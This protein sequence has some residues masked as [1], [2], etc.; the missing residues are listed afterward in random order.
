MERAVSLISSQDTKKMEPERSWSDLQPEILSLIL[1]NLF[2]GDSSNFRATC[3]SWKSI[4]P[5]FP[6][7]NESLLSKLPYLMTL[8]GSDCKIFQPLLKEMY[9]KEIPELKNARIRF[10]KYGWLLMSQGESSVFFFHPFTM[11]KIKLPDLPT[12]NWFHNMCFLNRPTSSDCTVI[13]ISHYSAGMEFCIIKRGADEWTYEYLE[14]NLPFCM[15]AASPVSH[16]GKPYCLG[17]GGNVG[18][19]DLSDDEWMYWDVLIKPLYRWPCSKYRQ[20]F[21]VKCDDGNGMLVVY[22][23]RE[24][25]RVHVKKLKLLEMLWEDVECLGDKMIF[26]SHG[27]S[28]LQDAV[29]K[30]MANKIYFPKFRGESGVFYSLDTGMFHSIV[31]DYPCR[32][33]FKLADQLSCTWLN[34]IKCSSS[35]TLSTVAE[36]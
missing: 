1:S 9:H 30:G 15:S 24:D 10:S 22:V 2:L 32:A 21:M 16:N 6:P 13:G 34:D 23:T 14:N 29:E 4:C 7:P 20:S 25:R 3:Q 27:A 19:L 8:N 18:E 31:G 33:S 12:R 5:P 26:L 36:W 11:V 17:E 28:F 35:C